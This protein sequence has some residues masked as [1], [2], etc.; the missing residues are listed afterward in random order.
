M[1]ANG[2]HFSLGALNVTTLLKKQLSE[3][4]LSGQK[5]ALT[6]ATGFLGQYMVDRLLKHQAEVVA[7]V[8]NPD[9]VP[10]LKNL[11]IEFRKADLGD[12]ES[13]SKAFDG[14]DAVISNAGQV[15][16]ANFS[17]MVSN[18]VGG[19]ENVFNAMRDAGVKRCVQTSSGS[20]YRYV[21]SNQVID[22]SFSLRTPSDR[23]H[24]MSSY[25]ISKAMAE[26]KAWDLAKEYGITLSTLR[27]FG[28]YGAFDSGTFMKWF[29]LLMKLQLAI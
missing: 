3:K 22:E 6:G 23:K 19:T 13:L 11:D 2:P 9:K 16:A 14:V 4:N 28:I 20:I 15:G 25:P 18:N 7:V 21:K 24:Y 27:P 8:R 5:I 29:K 17:E 10:A 12:K 1:G 26:N